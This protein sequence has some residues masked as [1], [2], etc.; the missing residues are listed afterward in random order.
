MTKLSNVEE[1]LKTK[2]RQYIEATYHINNSELIEK[3]RA[4]ID[5]KTSSDIW[6]ERTPKYLKGKN[7]EDLNLP[8]SAKKILLELSVKENSGVYGTPYAHQSDALTT[9]FSKK[10]NIVVS[11]GT[12]SGKT[13]IFL[14]SLLGL[15]SQEGERNG[16]TVPPIRGIRAIVLYP[17]NSL[18]SDQLSR[19]RKMIGKDPG[20]TILKNYFGRTVQFGMY[21]SR[22]PYFG[23][24]D[25]N[26]DKT[27]IRP[28]INYYVDLKNKQPDKYQQLDSMGRVP[29]KNLE[30]Y[31]KSYTTTDGDA[32]LFSRQEMYSD[33][34]YGGT[35]DILIT[36]YS[37]L[38]YILLRSI[39]APLLEDTIQWLNSNANNKLTIIID[40]AHLYYGSQG[41]EI[42]M[43][44]GRLLMKLG[45]TVDRVNF[46]L[47]SAS[48][49]GDGTT[50][51]ERIKFASS[52][53]GAPESSFEIIKGQ[54]EKTELIGSADICAEGI[55][56]F[57]ADEDYSAL[58][59][60]KAF[61]KMMS[62][63]EEKSLPVKDIGKAIFPDLPDHEAASLSEKMLDA[64]LDMSEKNIPKYPLKMHM[65]FRGM[66][67]QYLCINPK[68]NKMF[69]GA[70]ERCDKCGG[71]TFE[72]LTHRTCGAAYVR[73]YAPKGSSFKNTYFLWNR[74][75]KDSEEILLALEANNESLTEKRYI[76][77]Q[78]GFVSK[79]NN[80]GWRLIYSANKNN[81]VK[82]AQELWKKCPICGLDG[83]KKIM[84]LETKGEDVF[85]NLIKAVFE[86]QDKVEGNEHPNRG[87]KVLCFSDSRKKAARL[88]RDIQRNVEQDAF[89][90]TI[91]AAYRK[92]GCE[93]LSTL[94]ISF[95]KY[96]TD[97]NIYFFDDGDESTYGS[98][99]L[100][101]AAKLTIKREKEV[102]PVE[103]YDIHQ[104]HVRLLK[105]LGDDHFSLTAS[106]VAV[107]EPTEESLRII[108][109]K[110]ANKFQPEEIRT[111][112]ISTIWNALKERAYDKDIKVE[113]RYESR[114]TGAYSGYRQVEGLTLDE[115]V[116]SKL[117]EIYSKP[118]EYWGILKD[119]V[120]DV[121]FSNP[122]RGQGHF[123]IRPDSVRL[124]FDDLLWYRCEKCWSFSPCDTKNIC[125][126]CSGPLRLCAPDDKHLI[127]RKSLHR[128][129]YI[130]I[131]NEKRTPYNIRSEEH[132]AQLGYRDSDSINS[133]TEQYEL[134][135]QDIVINEGSTN[136]SPVDVLSCTTTMEVGIDIGSLTAVAL[137]TVPPRS[138]NYQQRAGRA[139]RRNSSLSTVITYADNKPYELHGF[140]DPG[141]FINGKGKTPIL[142]C[143]NEKI[144]KRHTNAALLNIFFFEENGTFGQGGVFS[145]M[146]KCDAFFNDSNEAGFSNFETWINEL[147]KQSTVVSRLGKLLPEE[148]QKS[149][150]IN[151]IDWRQDYVLSTSK[152]L[153]NS[154]KDIKQKHDYNGDEDLITRLLNAGLLPSFSFPLDVGKFV[155]YDT[156]SKN[157]WF[158]KFEYELSENLK[159]ALNDYV[160]GQEIVVDKKT[161]FCGGLSF[162]YANGKESVNDSIDSLKKENV[163]VCDECD[164]LIYSTDETNCSLCG[165][166]LRTVTMLRPEIFSPLLENGTKPS[167]YEE[168]EMASAAALPVKKGETSNEE[169]SKILDQIRIERGYNKT[170]KIINYGL[171]REGFCLCKSCGR[172]DYSIAHKS[173]N[174]KNP[175][176][177]RDCTD[178]ETLKIVLG[179]DLVT[180]T[181]TIRIGNIN[182]KIMK[183]GA[184][185]AASLSLKEGMIIAASEMLGIDSKELSGGYRII[186][187]GQSPVLELFLYDTTPSGAGFSSSLYDQVESVLDQTEE[188]LGRCDC[189]SSCQSCLR[190]YENRINHDTLDRFFALDLLTYARSGIIPPINKTKKDEYQ[191]LLVEAILDRIPDSIVSNNGDV[192][193]VKR[194][195]Q[196]KI[197]SIESFLTDSTSNENHMVVTDYDIKSNLPNIVETIRDSLL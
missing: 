165:K 17:M 49:G 129:P 26:K 161:F 135:F 188:T 50:D 48:L 157:T 34:S 24:R 61:K 2:H 52:L 106:L 128:N 64:C 114:K 90:E 36:N 155:V 150:G 152:E 105:A 163:N 184:L 25:S 175:I 43:L 59:A 37:M 20:K 98:R 186:M 14:Y 177:F 126:V 99:S 51:M 70:R 104:F 101:E 18:V 84:D 54:K 187:S 164:S 103:I 169:D 147:N 142:Y 6:I 55:Q 139:G 107:V 141:I 58:E 153:V 122:I 162:P 40:E 19:M 119:I 168:H 56:T 136:E 80:N 158:P 95:A 100:F 130:D 192:I 1:S 22:T 176:S 149:S 123:F 143:G 78:T 96:C 160:P 116:P 151:T 166:E 47:T 97:K 45:I 73:G 134:L 75:G 86:S 132:S 180:D 3:R 74:G 85:S 185:R 11:T 191:K 31:L 8:E 190:T 10:K 32:E 38:E 120:S 68:C 196:E 154:L 69:M 172:L 109:E 28:L 111:I 193:I 35:P 13:E 88:A 144:C 117:T 146:D 182:Q 63:L 83:D 93:D 94:F 170:L 113:D 124:T 178:T 9:F 5:E 76:N 171:K 79:T 127:A 44:I 137:R 173:G 21:T 121:L 156:K 87:R 60:T 138:D 65:V 125:V 46:I 57:L 183:N 81:R 174:H 189:D 7:I 82:N 15:F 77:P 4:I 118:P 53:T 41:A 16:G 108:N 29:T 167:K 102:S 12:G 181:I 30:N 133:K 145:S 110:M 92:Y 89:K 179:Y 71:R 140:E 195:L 72:L 23:K 194:G 115:I 39:E 159:Q 33:N 148:L 66:D 27:R 197:L 42:S 62:L 112:L 67:S 91:V 131:L